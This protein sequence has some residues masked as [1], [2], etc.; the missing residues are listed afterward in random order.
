MSN[1]IA[2]SLAE[3]TLV[4]EGSFRHVGLYR[5][6][7]RKMTAC[8]LRFLVP[9]AASRLDRPDAVTLLNLAFWSPDDV[10]EVLVDE[11]LTADQLAHNAWHR[12]AHDALGDHART[13]DGMLFAESIAS[14]FDV[15]LVGRLVGHAP[16][17]EFLETQVP[18][19]HDA[20]EAAGLD[21]AAFEGLVARMQAEPERSFEELRQLLFD[22]ATALV[23]AVDIHQ[24]AAILASATSHP[25]AALLH[26]YELP[27]WVLYARAYGSSTTPCDAVRALDHELREATD[28]LALLEARWLG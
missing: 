20:A 2:R 22:T 5:E 19:M 13:A 14:A 17:S 10:A 12:L 26:H 4:D 21:D 1:L 15:Y 18:A 25:M 7:K 9:T 11:V 23:P 8:D 24:A 16:D 27:T 28:S 6:L 3:L